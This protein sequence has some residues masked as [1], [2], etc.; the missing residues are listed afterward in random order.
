MKTNLKN[1]VDEV[2]QKA[3]HITDVAADLEKVSQRL[4]KHKINLEV[5]S[6]KRIYGYFVGKEKPT[7][8]TLDRIALF[9]GFQNWKDL[10]TAIH[11]DSDAQLNYNDEESDD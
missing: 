1:L 9:A 11:G 5:K 7:K 6:L 4:K 2:A 10:Q 3:P 8:K